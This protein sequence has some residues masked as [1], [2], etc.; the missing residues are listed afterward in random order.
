VDLFHLGRNLERCNAPVHMA[1]NAG[2]GCIKG[3]GFLA[4]C[5][6]SVS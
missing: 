4:S 3:G 2:R 1:M 6:D 5:I